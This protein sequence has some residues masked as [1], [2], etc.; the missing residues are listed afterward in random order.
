MPSSRIWPVCLPNFADLIWLPDGRFIYDTGIRD[1]HGFSCN[2]WQLQINEDT[3]LPVT[4]A[5][6]AHQLGWILPGQ[7]WRERE[8]VSNLFFRKRRAAAGY[9]LAISNMPRTKSA[10]RSCSRIRRAWNIRPHGRA[11]DKEVIFASNRNGPW[12]LLRQNI[13]SET[14]ELVASNLAGVADQTPLTPDGLSV[15][16]VSATA[17]GQGIHSKF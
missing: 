15:L 17:E 3:G 9:S 6:A 8:M 11:D 5:E 1:T 10:H 4:G 12:Q 13:T 14:A 16:N 2:Y 7:C